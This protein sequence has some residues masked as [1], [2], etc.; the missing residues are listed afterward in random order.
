[1]GNRCSRSSGG[2]SS[3]KDAKTTIDEALASHKVMVF[4]KA[5]CPYCAG[6]KTALKSVM[7]GN[8]FGVMELDARGDG[9]AIQ[10]ELLSI[11]GGRSVPRVFVEGKFIG[12]GDETMALAKNGELKKMLE[13]K[14]IL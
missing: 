8:S 6:A 7:G 10:D 3:G 1:M 11:T 2:D 9:S 5:Y 12:G 14:G 4:S 13:S